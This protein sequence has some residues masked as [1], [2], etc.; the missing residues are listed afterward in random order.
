M[1][2]Q[3]QRKKV[4]SFMKWVQSTI[5]SMTDGNAYHDFGF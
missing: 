1:G 5:L 2:K 4:T 3:E